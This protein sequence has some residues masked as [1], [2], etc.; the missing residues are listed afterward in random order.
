M[1]L[2]DVGPLEMRV[3]GLLDA[4]A[5]QSVAEIQGRLRSQG[6]EL[7]YTTVMT[8]LRRLHDKGLVTRHKVSRSHRYTT[9]RQIPKVK[10]GLMA[11]VRQA[12]FQGE[13][14]EP[15]MALLEDDR[16]STEE[17]SAL[18]GLI[19]AKLQERRR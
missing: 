1:A 10:A 17:L 8:V 16:L 3:L 15:I 19:D 9:S 4:E 18:R 2:P 5:P 6:T 12:L 7:A 14:A 13:R 11:R